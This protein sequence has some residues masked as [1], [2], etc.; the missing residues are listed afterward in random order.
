M[1]SDSFR[2]G[3]A[4]SVILLLRLFYCADVC[5]LTDK[6]PAASENVLHIQNAET[7]SGSF[8]ELSGMWG[9]YWNRFIPPEHFYPHT[10]QTQDNPM[11][12]DASVKIPA[13]V[14][15]LVDDPNAKKGKGS[16]TWHLRVENLKPNCR[17]AAFMFGK[18]GTAANVYCNTEL[19]FSQ[20]RAA[21]NYTETVSRRNMDIAFFESDSNGIADLVFHVSN[22]L[23]RKSGLWSPLRFAEE[24]YV[25]RWFTI[26]LSYNFF[27]L[28]ALL[29]IMFYHF[30]LF[31]LKKYD[32]S[33]FFFFLFVF[34]VLIRSISSEFSLLLF[35]IPSVPYSLDMKLEY[36]VIFMAPVFYILH[37]AFLHDVDLK[38]NTHKALITKCIMCIGTVLGAAIWL[39]PIRYANWLVTPC[40]VYLFASVAVIFTVLFIELSKNTFEIFV[41][42]AAGIAVVVLGIVHDVFAV[43][44]I[45][46]P[47]SDV[48]LVSYTFIIFLFFQSLITAI[49]HERA[50]DAI[51][52]LS[53]SMQETHKSYMRFLPGQFLRLLDKQNIEDVEIGDYT[54]RNVG[55]LC[56]DIRNFTPISERIGGKQVFDLLNTCF[57]DIAP[58]VRAHGGFIEKYLGDCIIA[59]FPDDT[60][61]MFRCAVE[62]QRNMKSLKTD[63]NLKLQIGIGLHYGKVV[64]GTTGSVDRLTQIAV[65][66]ALD[67]VMRLESLTKAFGTKILVS[68]ACLQHCGTEKSADE[69]IFV[70]LDTSGLKKPFGDDLYSLEEH[71]SQAG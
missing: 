11:P 5:A 56:A 45:R 15:N 50:A 29:S 41:L 25:R 17:Y 57:S 51:E 40:L 39:L 1:K 71:G 2:A 4:L 33:D 62:M 42:S 38:S 58:L 9:F 37:L 20:G 3:F 32:W 31:L 68:G 19:V 52:I 64:L 49:R 43:Q 63:E 14:N 28:G 55:L 69:F 16:A 54:L 23:Y 59:V 61:N 12:P 66:S 34:S 65:S 21:E 6:V 46:V 70:K 48:R 13:V 53:D 24:D 27:Y 22:D 26:K 35:Y 67:T 10:G 30:S 8:A 47:F 36:S 7:L 18:V 44:M 60:P